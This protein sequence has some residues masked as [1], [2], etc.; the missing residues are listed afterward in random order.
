MSLLIKLSA[1][2]SCA[3][4]LQEFIASLLAASPQSICLLMDERS[5]NICPLPR[6]LKL[7][8]PSVIKQQ[9]QPV[10]GTLFAIHAIF[11]D[12][13][14]ACTYA[15]VGGRKRDANKESD[16][17]TSG[18]KLKKRRWHFEWT[19]KAEA[20]AVSHLHL[21]VAFSTS[22]RAGVSFSHVCKV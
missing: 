11:H 13:A 3:C 16:S 6:K 21:T 8:L 18:R 2:K 9:K 10:G 22:T 19:S 5:A 1:Q 7:D 12:C 15:Y 4:V 14:P 17:K 20:V